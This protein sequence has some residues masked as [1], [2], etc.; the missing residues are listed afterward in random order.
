MRL[1]SP[2]EI[3]EAEGGPHLYGV[4]IQ[5]GRAARR[6]R[7]V[8]APGAVEWPSDGVGILTRHHG[9]AEVRAIPVREADGRITLKARATEAIRDAVAAG[10]RYMSVEFHA[11]REQRTEGGIREVLRALVPDVALVASPEYDMTSAEVR[12][13]GGFRTEIKTGR[14]MDCKCADGDA[15][16]VE[17][18]TDAFVGVGGLDVQAISRGAESVIA[19][20]ATGSL[21][22]ERT[23]AGIG[24]SLDPLDTEAGRRTRELLAA[25]VGVY[26]RPLWDP[27]R[28]DW[29]PAEGR[30]TES[31]AAAAIVTRAWFKYLLVRPVPEADANGLEPLRGGGRTRRRA[32]APRR[33]RRRRYL[34][35]AA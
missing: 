10:R 25:G 6:R 28:S 35:G 34:V 5:E 3:R 17:F 24:V 27:D 2:V 11:I 19:S 7:E 13:R 12:R 15:V 9:E 29:S 31:R 4:L 1:A 14:R 30:E 22:L 26:A 21:T 32:V 33:R 23:R 16:E 20:T 18:G 8:F